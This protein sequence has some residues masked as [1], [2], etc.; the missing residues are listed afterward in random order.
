MMKY[1]FMLQKQI[2][3]K[4]PEGPRQKNFSHMKRT[5]NTGMINAIPDQERKPK[6]VL[7][8]QCAS[9]ASADVCL[10]FWK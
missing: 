4:N 8:L 6:M 9:N 3:R 7:H 2:T 10:I 1:L 5:L